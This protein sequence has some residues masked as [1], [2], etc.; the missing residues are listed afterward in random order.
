MLQIFK[1]LLRNILRKDRLLLVQ[2]KEEDPIITNLHCG[3]AC[4]MASQKKKLKKLIGETSAHLLNHVA[5]GRKK[6][7]GAADAVQSKALSKA[8]T[9]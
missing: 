2:K 4:A 1:K 7:I 9:L 6:N 8:F 3:I 5:E